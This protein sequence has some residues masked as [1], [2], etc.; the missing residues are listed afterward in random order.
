MTEEEI[1]KRY[2]REDES[3][4]RGTNIEAMDRFIEMLKLHE[5]SEDS[6]I[7]SIAKDFDFF[8]KLAPNFVIFQSQECLFMPTFKAYQIAKDTNMLVATHEFGHA[9][10]SI[11]NHTEIPENYGEII[12][13]AKEYAL[14]PQNKENFK[15][16]IEYLAGKTDQ[17][18]ERT[19]GEKGPLSDIISSVFQLQGLRI[20]SYENVCWF[21]SSHSRDYYYDE[22]KELPKLK[23]IF[24]EDFANYYALKANNYTQEIETIRNLFGDELVQ[25]LDE[26]LQKAYK[27]LMSAKEN[28]VQEKQENPIEQIKSVIISSRQG[29]IE[30]INSLEFE[31]VE[32]K[33]DEKGEKDE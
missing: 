12:K 5:K 13:R 6:R 21:P 3:D 25:T 18:D 1:R 30:T 27:K 33:Q 10:L 28:K 16:Y 8:Y 20:G 24:D 15:T 9:V 17:K 23:H 29:E 14:L 26:E 22:A 7:R 2:Q 11:M 32:K 19:E 31:E 4:S